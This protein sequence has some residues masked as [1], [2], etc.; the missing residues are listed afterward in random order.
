MSNNNGSD[1][2]P[3]GYNDSMQID[4]NSQG[5]P[6]PQ[7]LNND[8]NPSQPPYTNQP[9]HTFDDFMH[10]TRQ[11]AHN[12]TGPPPMTSHQ[13]FPAHHGNIPNHSQ[14]YGNQQS[15][16]PPTFYTTIPS[17][18]YPNAGYGTATGVYPGPPPGNLYQP[19]PAQPG[20]F[21]NHPNQ[22]RAYGVPPRFGPPGFNATGSNMS[23]YPSDPNA[24][25]RTAASVYTVPPP[26]NLYQPS[27][28]HHGN[29][30][31]HSQ[32]YGVPPTLAPPSNVVMTSIMSPSEM[33][34][35]A[36][37]FQFGFPGQNPP[38]PNPNRP[39]LTPQRPRRSQRIQNQAIIAARHE[40]DD[41]TKNTASTAAKR[42]A[43]D[44][45]IN[46]DTDGTPP[47]KGKQTGG[48]QTGGPPNTNVAGGGIWAKVAAAGF[49][50]QAP[51]NIPLT[52]ST[53]PK[54]PCGDFEANNTYGQVKL[55][56]GHIIWSAHTAY[57]NSSMKGK[58]AVTNDTSRLYGDVKRN[59]GGW[60]WIEKLYLK[61]RYHIVLK[62]QEH[63]II[64]VPLFT[65]QGT[66]PAPDNK[67]K[68]AEYVMVVRSE[69][70]DV[71][72]NQNPTGQGLVLR[73]DQIHKNFKNRFLEPPNGKSYAHFLA[74]LC[75][76]REWDMQVMARLEEE[77]FS[78][79][80]RRFGNYFSTQ[81]IAPPGTVEN[82]FLAKLHSKERQSSTQEET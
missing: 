18:L 51:S 8:D 11:A 76:D 74:P 62:V 50:G 21:P 33:N 6:G 32:Q 61:K 57:L 52:P 75:L 56:P 55:K 44:A 82:V 43:D 65:Y 66:G 4:Q 20:N 80:L 81:T 41:A 7:P 36:R 38:Q 71:P 49:Q 17:P 29:I 79:L 1:N 25:H 28:A 14:G 5:F 27:P 63:H 31:N 37:S 13:P 64:T 46:M 34:P 70:P 35:N 15:F 19:S 30:P 48:I 39:N 24:G 22:S 47:K 26:E 42:G 23:S 16:G 53:K 72:Q 58:V 78:Q 69:H 45:E 10:E 59:S 77:S 3:E 9:G 60:G 68:R 2:L 67:R 40:A 12:Y 54:E 73:V